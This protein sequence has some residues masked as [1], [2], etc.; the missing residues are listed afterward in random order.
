MIEYKIR[1][2]NEGG[3]AGYAKKIVDY[4][5]QGTNFTSELNKDWY[6]ADNKNLYN[7]SLANTIIQPGETKEVTLLLTRKM[8]NDNTGII[9]NIA[10]IQ[11]SYNDL[12]LNDID[13]VAGNKVQTEDDIS[14][15]DVIIG[16]KTGEIYIYIALT[17]SL[18]TILGVGIYLINKKVLKK[19]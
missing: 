10:E 14:S 5:P 7:T 17:I 18:V 3:V 16:I 1:V 6:M 9:N 11:E 19:M 13:S 15:A 2:T 8:T 12:G 4:M